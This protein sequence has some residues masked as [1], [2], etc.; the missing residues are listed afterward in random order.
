LTYRA[1]H[2]LEKG[3]PEYTSD[4]LRIGVMGKA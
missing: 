3:I 2:G 4:Y 1:S